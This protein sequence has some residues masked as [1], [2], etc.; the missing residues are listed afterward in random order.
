MAISE[1]RLEAFNEASEI[2][3]LKGIAAA[4]KRG[5]TVV[6]GSTRNQI[7]HWVRNM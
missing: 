1:V 7:V 2:Q 3:E 4:Q 6:F 5:L